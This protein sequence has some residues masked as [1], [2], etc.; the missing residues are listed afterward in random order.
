M[1]RRVTKWLRQDHFKEYL[2]FGYYPYFTEFD[3]ISSYYMT[4]EQGIRTTIES[5]LLSIYPT[6]N[7][8]SIKKIKKLLSVIAE[9]VP[10]SPD[11]KRLN[12]SLPLVVENVQ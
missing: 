2:H 11:L 7:G 5:D 8:G 3:D 12:P 9:S 6:L 10:F 1:H 4:L